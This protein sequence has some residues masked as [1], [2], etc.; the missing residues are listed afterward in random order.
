MDIEEV[1]VEFPEIF[2]K[3]IRMSHIRA[4]NVQ[5][6]LSVFLQI[7]QNVNAASYAVV[8]SIV[9]VESFWIET[10]LWYLLENILRVL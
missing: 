1:V 7:F 5:N 9:V 8:F 2:V 10:T 6:Q 4:L 3:E